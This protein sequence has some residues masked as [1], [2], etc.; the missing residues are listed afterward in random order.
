[1]TL[2]LK[3]VSFSYSAASVLENINLTLAHSQSL[4]IKGGNGAGKTTLLKIISGLLTPRKGE[5]NRPEKIS[6]FLGDAF[7]YEKV[8]LFEN[9]ELYR[10]L[11]LLGS[12][13]LDELADLFEIK[14]IWHRPYEK[15]SRGERV[16]GGLVRALMPRVDLLLLDEPFSH[17][18]DKGCLQLQN[19][20]NHLKEN[21]ASII[22]VSHQDSMADFTFDRRLMMQARSLHALEGEV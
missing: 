1:M 19:Y 3:K 6:L 21:G 20:L 5:V 15:L 12:P 7:F 22:L 11:Q 13:V 18:D 17:L 4:W 9:L 2:S 10:K 8:S 16:R 14:K